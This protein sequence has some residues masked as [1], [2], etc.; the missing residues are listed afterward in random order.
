MKRTEL[1]KIGKKKQA[2][3]KKRGIKAYSTFA[4]KN[5]KGLRQSPLKQVSEKR[6]RELREYYELIEFLRILC[7]N[8]SELSGKSPDW[9]SKY[10]VEA[11]HINGR[12]G[13]RLLNPFEL[14]MITRNEHDIEEGK[15][16]DKKPTDP[17]KL[18]RI[19][20]EIRLRQGFIP[21]EKEQ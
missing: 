3:L 11:H 2:E 15:V 19:V 8:K 4:K 14:I 7:D 13:D 17:K 20:K 9:Q 6:K 10:K 12:N 5:N 21:N 16:K 1:N 18:L